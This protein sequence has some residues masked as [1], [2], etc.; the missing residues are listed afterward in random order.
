MT[1]VIHY[2]HPNSTYYF[3]IHLRQKANIIFLFTEI[4][5]I[6]LKLWQFINRSFWWRYSFW[7]KNSF[8]QKLV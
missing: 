2:S 7:N 8:I 5:N 4:S 1:I 3:V 6:C